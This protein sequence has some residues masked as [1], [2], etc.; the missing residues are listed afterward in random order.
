MVYQYA[1]KITKNLDICIFDYLLEIVS[2]ERKKKIER[3]KNPK[4]QWRSLFA[5]IILRYALKQHYEL[6]SDEIV[7]SYHS[8]EKPFLKNHPT[9]HFNLSHAGDWILCGIGDVSLGVDIELITDIDLNI[10]KRFFNEYEYKYLLSRPKEE[11]KK[12]FFHLWT[13]KE[14]YVKEVGK[15]LGMAL[16]SFYFDMKGNEII[17]YD[18]HGERQDYCFL[19]GQLEVGYCN[20]I[21]INNNNVK[22]NNQNIIKLSVNDLINWKKQDEEF[23]Q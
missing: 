1:V 21:C 6:K 11:Q 3:Y 23:N 15:G 16:D 10:A 19:G 5:E 14:S 7:F 8:F 17:M 2:N 22:K 12:D 9:I 13:L 4:D 20:A 18:K